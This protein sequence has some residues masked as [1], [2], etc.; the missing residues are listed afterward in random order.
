MRPATVV[1]RDPTLPH[2]IVI[3]TRW[4]LGR[5]W[6]Y[7]SCNCR[8]V[9]GEV[10]E[11]LDVRELFEPGAALEVWRAHMAEVAA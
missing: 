2:Q 8:R 4:A 7:V 5:T 9:A 11:P 1:Y 10:Y 3:S 6:L